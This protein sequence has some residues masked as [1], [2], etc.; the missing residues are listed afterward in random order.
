MRQILYDVSTSVSRVRSFN[1]ALIP[2]FRE[3]PMIRVVHPAYH[4]LPNGGHGSFFPSGNRRLSC[5]RVF[6]T[7][8]D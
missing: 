2:A 5:D 6:A 4:C 7:K 3:L 8:E 1:D